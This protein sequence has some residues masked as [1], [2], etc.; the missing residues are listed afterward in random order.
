MHRVEFTSIDACQFAEV[1]ADELLGVRQCF[2]EVSVITTCRSQLFGNLAV[3]AVFVY[4]N[5]ILIDLPVAE[6]LLVCW[7]DFVTSI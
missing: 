7:I 6:L 2:T 3:L 1:G 5:P 4:F